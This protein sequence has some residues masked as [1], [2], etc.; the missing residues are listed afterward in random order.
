MQVRPPVDGAPDD[1]V[2]KLDRV[3]IDAPCTGSGTWRRRP[4]AKW[5]LTAEQVVLR[6][7][8]QRAILDAGVRYVRPGGELAYITCSIL[9]EENERQ[10]SAFLERHPEFEPVPLAPALEAL[11][12]GG[13]G[14]VRLHPSGGVSLT[15]LVSETDGFFIGLFRRR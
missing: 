11:A 9:D 3:V 12:A 1:L 10:A 6:V 8:E 15:P 2:G 14:R 7:G 4:D 5:K 13:S